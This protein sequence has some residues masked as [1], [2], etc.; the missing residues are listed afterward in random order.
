MA[1]S[2]DIRR[3]IKS[4][5]NIQ[6][7]TQAMKLVASA[8]LQKAQSRVQAARP[9]AQ[10]IQEIISG[11]TASGTP[12]DHPLLQARDE[13]NIALIVVGADRGLAGSYH[14]NIIRACQRFLKSYTPEQVSIFAMGKKGIGSVVKLGYPVVD[15]LALPGTD[16]DFA[17]IRPLSRKAQQMFS[18]GE[19]DAVYLLYTQF[20][21]AM[22][23]K[24]VVQRLLPVE[25]P[26]AEPG[27][28]EPEAA[29]EYIFEP[30]PKELLASLL[31]RYVDTLLFRSVLESVT[32]EQGARMTAMSSA[33]TNAGEMI[34]RLTLSLNRARQAS[35]TTEIAEIVG[36]AEALK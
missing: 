34:D 11:L 5:K 21:S 18:D 17:T 2:R 36:T 13:K 32:S 15:K 9:Y 24:A 19:V 22:V 14:S 20:H 4:V 28:L 27:G 35:I 33:T 16:V 26:C 12:L 8:R 7:I 10:K 3:R 23:Q 1:S 29:G 25:P 6:Q 30:E 31:S